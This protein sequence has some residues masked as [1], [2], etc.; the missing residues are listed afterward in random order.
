MYSVWEVEAI[1]D[2]GTC[3]VAMSESREI[4]LRK[5]IT[6]GKRPM[7]LL[8]LMLLTDDRNAARQMACCEL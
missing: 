6:T 3:L 5:E 4:S 2:P 8:W 7:R 1:G